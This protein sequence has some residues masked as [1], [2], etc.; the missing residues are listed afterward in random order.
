MKRR[1]SENFWGF[2]DRL[3]DRVAAEDWSW[4]KT[5]QALL[6]MGCL[7][8]ALVSAA[9]ELTGLPPWRWRSGSAVSALV[10]A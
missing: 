9:Y 5:L 2:A 1:A 7:A 6:L 4:S 3:L 10:P 8:A